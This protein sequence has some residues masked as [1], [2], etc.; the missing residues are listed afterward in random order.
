M[1]AKLKCDCELQ[2]LEPQSSE[3]YSTLFNTRA[4]ANVKMWKNEC[5]HHCYIPAFTYAKYTVHI[6]DR[7][8]E[9]LL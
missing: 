8:Q 1:F 3:D 4:W 5:Y 6:V 9:Q 7:A 2:A